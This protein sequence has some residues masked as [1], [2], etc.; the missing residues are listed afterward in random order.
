[1]G[2]VLTHIFGRKKKCSGF[3]CEH[4]NVPE[5]YVSG[6]LVYSDRFFIF[7][8]KTKAQRPPILSVRVLDCHLDQG[9]SP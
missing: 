7:L 2:T 8:K 6:R 9:G 3:N 1:M 5:D 4:T